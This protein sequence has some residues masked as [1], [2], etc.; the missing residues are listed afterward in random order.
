[1]AVHHERSPFAVLPP[2]A[3]AGDLDAAERTKC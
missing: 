1:M 3:V 2:D